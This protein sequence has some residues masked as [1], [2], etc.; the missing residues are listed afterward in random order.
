MKIESRDQ[1]VRTLLSSGYFKIPRFQR[2]YS[3]DRENIQDFWNDVVTDKSANYFIG[4]M[5]VYKQAAQVFGVVDGQQRLT[6]ITILLCAMRNILDERGLADLA[7]G[8]HALIERFNIDNE[9][10]FVV[11][12]ESSYPYFQDKIQKRG[13]PSL[14]VT[15][16][17]EEKS[18]QAAFDQITNLLGDV[19]ASIDLD[20]STSDARKKALLRKK[21]IEIRDAVLDLNLITVQLDD[22][23]DAYV[24]FETLNTRGKD[25]SL[26]DLVKNHITRHARSRNRQTD[27]A[28]LK[29]RE[30]LETIEGSPSP[31]ATETFLHHFWLSKY[32]YLPAKSLFKTLKKR[33]AGSQ[34]RQF[35]DDLVLDAK[36]YRSLYDV[37]YGKWTKQEHNL[38]DS[39]VA[40]QL[41]RVSQPIPCILSLMREYKSTKKL[42]LTHVKDALLAIERFHFLF[43]AVTSQR[44]S[45]GISQMYASHARQLAEASDTHAAVKTLIELKDKLRA[46]IPSV[47]EFNALFPEIVYTDKRSKQRKLVRYVLSTLDRTGPSAAVIDYEKMTIEHLL[48]QSQVSGVLPDEIVGQLGNLILVPEELN[49]KLKDKDFSEKKRLLESNGVKLPRE[50][51]GA[52]QWGAEEIMNRTKKL[53]DAAYT[54]AWKI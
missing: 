1:D 2:P 27:D 45:G 8:I 54:K 22:E 29:W 37:D 26:T 49:Q 6:T 20:K 39:L 18:L 41:F 51:S 44:S 19:V 15:P 36:L 33:I 25:L 3:W 23:D 21:M 28:K 42:R 4:S 7:T 35:L 9:P 38:S 31:I 10:V 14:H 17:E 48:P 12:T 53:S 5:V 34:V 24:I 43:T 11:S 30:M 52:T 50:I 46:R 32:D 16:L 40:L 47:D 13:A